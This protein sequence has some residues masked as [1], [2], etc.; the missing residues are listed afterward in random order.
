MVPTGEREMLNG[1]GL[2]SLTAD[3]GPVDIVYNM[4]IDHWGGRAT[5]RLNVLDFAAAE[6]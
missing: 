5:L 2:H 6:W 4:E 1:S 3:S